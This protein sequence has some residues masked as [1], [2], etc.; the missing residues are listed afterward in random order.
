LL[1]HFVFP[2]HRRLNE[3]KSQGVY[4]QSAEELLNKLNAEVR[5]MNHRKETIESSLTQRLAYM[6]K[7]QSWDSVDKNATEV[8]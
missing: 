7:M 8:D 5:E 4:N 2:R 3:T 1:F 6:E